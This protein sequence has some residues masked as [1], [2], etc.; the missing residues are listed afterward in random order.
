[1]EVHIFARDITVADSCTY[2]CDINE[3]PVEFAI[4]SAGTFKSALGDLE[5][6]EAVSVIIDGNCPGMSGDII[7]GSE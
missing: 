2:L 1:M 3:L 5:V 4:K 7:T 6:P